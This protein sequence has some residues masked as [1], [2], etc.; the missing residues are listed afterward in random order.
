[1]STMPL[2]QRL[3][4]KNRA[5]ISTFR[6]DLGSWSLDQGSRGFEYSGSATDAFWNKCQNHLREKIAE[7]FEWIENEVAK[8]PLSKNRRT[9]IEQCVGAVATYGRQVREIAANQHRRLAKLDNNVD[10]GNWSGLDDKYVMSRGER[11]LQALGLDQGSSITSKLN[12][13][14]SDHKWLPIIL[15]VL[16]MIIAIAAYLKR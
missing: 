16:S 8:I 11:L 5:D 2:A 1:M 10:L 12:N 13:L 14:V 9:S 4:D 15:S 3:Y 6:A 7:Y